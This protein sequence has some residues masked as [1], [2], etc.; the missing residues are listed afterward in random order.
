MDMIKVEIYKNF[1]DEQ[2]AMT[3]DEPWNGPKEL[4]KWTKMILSAN[5]ICDKEVIN[6]VFAELEQKYNEEILHPFSSQSVAW[7]KKYQETIC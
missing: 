4:K 3:Y 2:N 6:S 1:R 5:G 7:R